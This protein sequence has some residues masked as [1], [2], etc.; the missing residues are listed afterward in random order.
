MFPLKPG[1]ATM[2]AE[3]LARW[4]AIVPSLRTPS[5]LL[6]VTATPLP[7][8][9]DP[10]DVM[11][12]SSLSVPVAI[13]VVRAVLMVVSAAAGAATTAEMASRQVDES[14]ERIETPFAAASHAGLAAGCIQL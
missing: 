5:L 6:M 8:L 4:M 1:K 3:L 7:T 14:S 9:I 12:I 10:V 13:G 11:R 2:P